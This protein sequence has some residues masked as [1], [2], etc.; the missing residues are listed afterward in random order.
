M[1]KKEYHFWFS[2]KQKELTVTFPEC[3]GG[4]KKAKL[5]TGKIVE[6]TECTKTTKGSNFDDFEYLGVG[7]IYSI[8]GV[9]QQSWQQE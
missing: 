3:A 8:R 4:E 1:N 6:Y 9:I 7:E 5:I 2:K